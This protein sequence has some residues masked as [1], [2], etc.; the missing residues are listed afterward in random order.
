MVLSHTSVHV[1]CFRPGNGFSS[2]SH[3]DLHPLRVSSVQFVLSFGRG[4]ERAGFAF[5]YAVA[6]VCKLTLSP[7]S[8]REQ[9][10]AETSTTPKEA[11]ILRDHWGT[12]GVRSKALRLVR[13]QAVR[14]NER[15]KK[16]LVECAMRAALPRN[17]SSN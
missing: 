15:R 8:S 16:V 14:S 11:R 2:T 5:S 12:N 4:G 1:V 6:L 7:S 13:T 10:R 9:P 17:V 3:C